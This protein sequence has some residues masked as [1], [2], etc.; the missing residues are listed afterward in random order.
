MESDEALYLKY[1]GSGDENALKELLDRH[2]VGLTYF[3]Y[4]YIHNMDDAEELMLDAFAVTVSK[5]AH[6]KS[7]KTF[8]TWLYTIGRNLAISRVR[9]QHISEVAVDEV[10]E[11]VFSVEPEYFKGE[12]Y[13]ALYLAL[14]KLK[15]DYR[16]VLFLTYF[17]D[18]SIDAVAS[19]MKKTNK[20]IYNLIFQGKKALKGKL[21]EM[22]TDYNEFES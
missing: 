2:R 17:E 7:D 1:T 15:P 22:G 8:K 12:K 10:P 5:T 3:L 9:K 19:I 6:F 18:R 21:M 11:D 20:Q 13:K 14:E 16:Q 4:G